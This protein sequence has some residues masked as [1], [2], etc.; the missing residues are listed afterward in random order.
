MGC[1]S[2]ERMSVRCAAALNDVCR[3]STLVCNRIN[4]F[5]TRTQQGVEG[6]A[7]ERVL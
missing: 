3:V 2:C 4:P 7:L 6:Y 1:R 5:R